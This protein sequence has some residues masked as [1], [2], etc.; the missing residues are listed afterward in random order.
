MCVKT[1]R[2]ETVFTAQHHQRNLLIATIICLFA[3]ALTL[4]VL[5]FSFGLVVHYLKPSQNV[6]WNDYSPIFLGFVSTIMFSSV[7]YDL[8]VFR[9]GGHSLAKQMGAR[10]LKYDECAPEEVAALELTE[11]L[12]CRFNIDVPTVYVLP[13]EV[14]VNALTAGRYSQDTVII[15]TWGALQN[16]DELELYGLLSYAFNQILTGEMQQNI[17]LKILFSALTAFNQIGSRIARYGFRPYGQRK[18]Y[19]LETVLVAIGGF[20]W[21]MGS[22]G[23]LISRL[24]KFMTLSGRTL[25]ND[26]RTHELIANDT[27]LQ[28]LLRIYVHHAGSQIHSAY[29][30]SI[31]HMCFAN[32]LSPQSWLNIHPSIERRIYSLSPSALKELQ[33]EN[34]KRL[35]TQPFFSLFRPFSES[36]LEVKPIWI[37]PKPLPLLRLSPIATSSKDEIKPLSA[38]IRQSMQR[39]ELLNRALQTS[40]GAKEVLIAIFMIRQYR[41]FIP[42]DALVSHA[43]IDTLLTI[44][45]RLYIQ[46]FYD[47]CHRL[48]YMPVSTAR[49]F[50]TRIACIIQADG[51]IGLLDHLL[52]EYVRA[53]LNLLPPHMPNAYDEA[54]P[55]TIRLIDALLHVQQ[56]NSATQLKMRQKVIQELVPAQDWGK[57]LKLSDEPIDL[58]CILHHLS[59][60]LLR[61]R[62]K[63]LGIAEQCLWTDHVITQDELDVLELLYWRLGFE[64]KET[65]AQIQKRNNVVIA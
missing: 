20:I 37:P 28:T 41:E 53:K 58:S 61:D 35:K 62:L 64:S 21:L 4:L 45:E 2:T 23:L 26:Y 48:S 8:Y 15:L 6:G 57:Y 54:L 29:S 5:N 39:S 55:D 60:L 27:N 49:Q 33:L 1:K 18:P 44:D 16:L 13:H 59:G 31:A 9:K 65:V 56:F 34:L 43:I 47:A 19:K 46:I 11:K 32:S 40:T 38:E 42:K 14:G 30:E 22:L 50:L 24:I 10:Y 36:S 3:V 17:R 51:E 52:L 63:V 12:A 25:K 7:I